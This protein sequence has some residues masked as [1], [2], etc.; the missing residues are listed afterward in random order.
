MPGLAWGNPTKHTW[1]EGRL[2]EEGRWLVAGLTY[3]SHLGW[4]WNWGWDQRRGTGCSPGDKSAQ[5]VES[6][7]CPHLQHI[8]MHRPG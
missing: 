6:V 4:D 1:A 3:G 8:E 7:F 2:R 5:E